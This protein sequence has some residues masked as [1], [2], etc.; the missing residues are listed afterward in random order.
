MAAYIVLLCTRGRYYSYLSTMIE[1]EDDAFYDVIEKLF[2][3]YQ[4]GTGQ[5][6][7]IYHLKE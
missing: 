3:F 7:A 2:L 4:F 1:K 6:I 5:S